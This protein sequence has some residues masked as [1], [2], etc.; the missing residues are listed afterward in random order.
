MSLL[1]LSHM[2]DHARRKPQ[3]FIENSLV[4]KKCQRK[5]F[6]RIDYAVQ[7]QCE[8]MSQLEK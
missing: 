1:E 6:A 5:G 7:L 3:C 4:D 2:I 8:K